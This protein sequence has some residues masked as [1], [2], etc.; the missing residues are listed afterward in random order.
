MTFVTVYMTCKDE[1]E[2]EKIVKV[3]VE[4]RLAGCVNIVP[5]IKSIYWWNGKITKDNESLLL[6][7]APA[8]NKKK[9]IE[10]VKK[11]HSYTTPCIN[12]L[13]VEIGNPDF[14]KWLENE[15][16]NRN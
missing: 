8:R 5:S 13:P 14:R 9:I 2:A 11:N 7:K 4:K 16:K 10:T 3:L 15:T 12:F 1:K 6:A